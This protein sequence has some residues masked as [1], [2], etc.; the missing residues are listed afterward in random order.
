M[1]LPKGGLRGIICREFQ[2]ITIHP[3]VEKRYHPIHPNPPLKKEGEKYFPL[4]QRGTEGDSVLG[5]FE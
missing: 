2:Y 5:I 1:S 3:I 4:S